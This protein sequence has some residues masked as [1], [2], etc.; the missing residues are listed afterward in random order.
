MSETAQA[1]DHDKVIRDK[2]DALMESLSVLRA[3]TSLPVEVES[4]RDLIRDALA[5]LIQNHDMQACSVFLLTG[6]ELVNA[7]GM[8][9]SEAT[10]P[11]TL[12]DANRAVQKFRIGQGII[13]KA[14]ELCSL[15]RCDDCHQ[16]PDF[17][18]NDA[19]NIPGS[20]ICTPIEHSGT[21]IGVLNVSHPNVA[22]FEDW[23]ERML[24]IY[25][26]TLGLLIHNN[27]LLISMERQIHD[28][29][30]ELEVALERARELKA[31]SEEAA[32]KDELTGLYTRRFF[33]PQAESALA[34]AV[35]YKQNFSILLIDV[36]F[37]RSL[38]ANFGHTVGDMVLQDIAEVVEDA[39][40]ECD[41]LARYAGEEFIIA[42][43][44]TDQ[45][46]AVQLAERIS[47]NVRHLR[48]SHDG[49]RIG[50]TV[51]IGIASLDTEAWDM[52][53]TNIDDLLTQ[54]EEAIFQVRDAGRGQIQVYQ[55]SD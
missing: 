27:R 11:E 46:G 31:G 45:H 12:A 23:H 37:F 44:D 35:R 10:Q 30:H 6:Q 25:A 49:E 36:D 34:R 15:Q 40:R 50:S 14:A 16:S 4:E 52:A 55:S 29:S 42:V 32:L 41:I 51:C 26:G 47:H 7:T 43:P 1:I 13:G 53:K 22:F 2:Y 18:Q 5:S 54:A 9:W 28:R 20:V 33:F 19:D 24:T 3:L 48:W 17:V 21:L 39:V 8:D 38:N